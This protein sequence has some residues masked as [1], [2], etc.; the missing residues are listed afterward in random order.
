MFDVLAL[1]KRETVRP[2]HQI[3]NTLVTCG[4]SVHVPLARIVRAILPSAGLVWHVWVVC[5]TQLVT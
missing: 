4:T 2:V 5:V 3:L 1:G